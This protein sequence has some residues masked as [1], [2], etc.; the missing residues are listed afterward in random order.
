[1]VSQRFPGQTFHQESVM[2]TGSDMGVELGYDGAP[3]DAL[4]PLALLNLQSRILDLI[5]TAIIAADLRGTILLGHHDRALGQPRRGGRD[6]RG[7]Q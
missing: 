1:M 7:H 3:G 2:P 6:R 4:P 5:D